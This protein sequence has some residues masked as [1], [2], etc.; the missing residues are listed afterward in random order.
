L[1]KHGAAPNVVP[2]DLAHAVRFLKTPKIHV[3]NA[4]V[5]LRAVVT[6]TTDLGETFYPHDLDLVVT[7]EAPEVAGAEIY[8]R[9]K[10]HWKAGSRS[11]PISF[12]LA[13]QDLEWPACVHVEARNSKSDGFLPPICEIWSGSIN[14]VKGEFDSGWRVERRFTSASDRPLSL[15]EDAG[16]SIARHLWDGSQA[17]AQHIDD[18]I[19]GQSSNT[20]PLLEYVLVSATYRRLNVLE[21]GCGAG[22]VGISIAQSIPDCDVLLTDLDEA[23]ELVAA[24]IARMQPA[25]SSRARFEPLDWLQTLPDH[26]ASRNNHMIVVSECTYNADTLEPL[27]GTL[28]NLLVRSPK[29]LII[30]A[31]KTRHPDEARFFTLLQDIG[32]IAEGSLRFLLPGIPGDGYADTAKDVGLHLFRGK[33]HRLALTPRSASDETVPQVESGKRSKSR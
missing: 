4:N 1:P 15:L 8:L 14:A 9:R 32:I 30:V 28:L 22:T 24:N 16:E 31:T 25:M 6:V 27:A 26:I 33:D 5:Q 10:L 18:T 3:D 21:L 11:L 12:E 2:T 17:L 19:A 20:L 23:S 29:A 13:R 7:I